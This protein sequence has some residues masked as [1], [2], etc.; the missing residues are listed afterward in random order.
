MSTVVMSGQMFQ[1]EKTFD[2]VDEVR[3]TARGGSMPLFTDEESAW[4][5]RLTRLAVT[6][7]HSTMTEDHAVVTAGAVLD[8]LAEN[9]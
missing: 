7:D 4:G 1:R 2:G 3:S 6:G 5:D 8:R 9:V